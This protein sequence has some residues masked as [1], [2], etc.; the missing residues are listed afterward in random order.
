MD[1]KDIEAI[2]KQ[3]RKWEVIEIR[4]PEEAENERGNPV[5]EVALIEGPTVVERY[6][7]EF[8]ADSDPGGEV[9]RSG[10]FSYSED[11]DLVENLNEAS[12]KASKAMTEC[13]DRSICMKI[14]PK[15]D[16]GDMMNRRQR[17]DSD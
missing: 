7:F 5:V 13:D 11:A 14:R 17:P 9:Y 12:F 3:M 16:L 4:S 1:V 10:P 2:R 6:A 15:S 8:V